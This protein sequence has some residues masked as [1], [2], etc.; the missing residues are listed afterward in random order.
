MVCVTGKTPGT[1]GEREQE[2][3]RTN[4]DVWRGEF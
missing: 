3:S 2:N 4:R 1:M